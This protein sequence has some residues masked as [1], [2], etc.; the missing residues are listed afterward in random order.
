MALNQ[1]RYTPLWNAIKSD[2]NTIG[3]NNFNC[4]MVAARWL[5]DSRQPSYQHVAKRFGLTR[6]RVH[7]ICR[8]A[9]Q[10]LSNSQ[11]NRHIRTAVNKVYHAIKICGALG[12]DSLK[13]RLNESGALDDGISLSALLELGKLVSPHMPPYVIVDDKLAPVD[14]GEGS[15]LLK[16]PWLTQRL[17][18]EW[19]KLSN[20][21]SRKC[22]GTLTSKA[23]NNAQIYSRLKQLLINATC[24]D[25]WDEGPR[26]MK[27][28]VLAR[29]NPLFTSIS[30][31]FSISNALPVERVAAAAARTLRGRGADYPEEFEILDYLHHHCTI[32]R[33]NSRGVA[34][35]EREIIPATK[36]Q[37]AVATVLQSLSVADYRTLYDAAAKQTGIHGD[38]IKKAILNSPLIHV[39]VRRGESNMY[40][41]INAD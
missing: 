9:E 17:R 13:S 29:Q 26:K 18:T 33:C 24:I 14:D 41:L 39:V 20:D 27:F 1:S 32:I 35:F 36:S 38:T 21:S 6:Q 37:L 4:A 2:L 16:R 40:R 10:Q 31:S 11:N 30:R 23:I 25:A 12:C 3:Y 34:T 19:L 5:Y 28:V 15:Y 7:Q 22:I 8:Q